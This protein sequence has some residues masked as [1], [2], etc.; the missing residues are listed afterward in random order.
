MVI[1]LIFA[2]I[3]KH[4][5]MDLPKII[6]PWKKQNM[7]HLKISL[8]GITFV[9]RVQNKRTGFLFIIFK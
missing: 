4:L 5:T 2:I 9:A 1:K 8:L 6:I 3:S 7:K